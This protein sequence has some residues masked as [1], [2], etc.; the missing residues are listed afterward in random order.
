MLNSSV[1]ICVRMCVGVCVFVYLENVDVGGP[2][3]T[4][5]AQA[6]HGNDFS[7]ARISSQ[8]NNHTAD[9]AQIYGGS[10]PLYNKSCLLLLLCGCAIFSHWF[11]NVLPLLL[12]RCPF[13]SPLPFIKWNGLLNRV[14]CRADYLCSFYLPKGSY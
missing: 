9:N 12:R 4:V 14:L 3:G 7:Q 5:D 6:I 2:P 11:C 1:Y 10:L 8:K 13:I